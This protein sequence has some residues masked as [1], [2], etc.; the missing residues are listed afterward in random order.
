MTETNHNASHIANGWDFQL[1]AAIVLFIKNIKNSKSVE[2]EG[3]KEDIEI[4]LNDGS[5]I[6]AQV[7]STYIDD[8]TSK[9]DESR[10]VE[11]FKD[12]LNTLCDADDENVKNLVY[13]INSKNPFKENDGFYNISG[14]TENNFN[15]LPLANQ[16]RIKQ[17][18]RSAITNNQKLSSFNLNKLKIITIPFAGSLSNKYNEI[19][20]EIYRLLNFLKI[21]PRYDKEFAEKLQLMFWQNVTARHIK[22]EKE[23]F[24]WQL[25]ILLTDKVN[26]PK[27][28]LSEYDENE[29][30][31]IEIKFK[32]VIE[33][34]SNDFLFVNHVIN[35]YG[36][37]YESLQ[38][39]NNAIRDFI[40]SR[41]GDFM[42][43]IGLDLEDYLTKGVVKITLYN[44]LSNKTNILKI[45]AGVNLS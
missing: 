19:Y 15:D 27:D 21:N 16:E 43:M 23:D 45:K 34:K 42:G 35:K 12:A 25:I 32:S 8:T 17:I 37:F 40:N 14:I 13:I 1:N 4:I 29:L 22:L 36:E 31:E 18:L 39:R 11:K 41:Y 30:N 9:I 24:V 20:Q 3:S 5:K 44:I 28:I 10:N 7:K 33:R 26:I 6:M 38:T 2:V